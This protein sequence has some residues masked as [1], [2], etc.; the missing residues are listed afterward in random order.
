LNHVVQFFRRYA[1]DLQSKAA[2]N[3]S[4]H[5]GRN[6]GEVVVGKIGRELR[7]DYTAHGNRQR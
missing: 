2:L 3:F 4:V 6:L 5:L 1:D 7:M